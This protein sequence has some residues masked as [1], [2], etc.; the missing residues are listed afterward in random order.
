M[1]LLKYSKRVEPSNEEK[2]ESV[3]PE[4]DSP[5]AH[6]MPSSVTEAANGAVREVLYQEL[7]Q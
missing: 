7:Y 6:S 4:P 1:V 3:L 2:I 5:L